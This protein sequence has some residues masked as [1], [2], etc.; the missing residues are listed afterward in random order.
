MNDEKVTIERINMI[1]KT[2]TS[3]P[4]HARGH[5]LTR[6]S[7]GCVV[8]DVPSTCPICKRPIETLR[9]AITRADAEMGECAKATSDA[10][11]S[12]ADDVVVKALSLRYYVAR[13]HYSK[14][15]EFAKVPAYATYDE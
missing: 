7:C 15:C 4:K 11:E 8:Y 14:L 3:W 1:G 10:R 13:A 6:L 2:N 9:D 12:G 5:L